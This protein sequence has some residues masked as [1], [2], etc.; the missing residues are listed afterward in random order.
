MARKITVSELKCACL[1]PAWRA[2][3]LAGERPPT[4]LHLGHGGV[5]TYSVVF[6]RLAEVFVGWLC[7]PI[8]GAASLESGEALWQ[9]LFDRFASDELTKL[10]RAN[11]VP[12]SHRFKQSLRAF[13]N[14]LAD[15]R[16]GAPAFKVWR[17]LYLGEEFDLKNVHIETSR[18]ALLIAGRV[19]AVRT[20][21]VH[22]VEVID[23][24]LSRG[25][26]AKHDLIQLAIYSRML[27]IAKPGLRFH[28]VLEY[29]EPELH[30]L[31]VPVQQLDSLFEEIVAP[32]LPELTSTPGDRRARGPD[33]AH[34]VKPSA[35]E[36]D[37][38]AAA[39][40]DCFAAFKLEVDVMD[41]IEAP[42]LVRYR[43]RPAPG[44]K[45]VSLANR[46]EDLQVRLALLQPPRIE[47]AQGYVHI[48]IPRSKPDTV[49]WNDVIKTPGFRQHPSPIA[50]PV[51]MGVDGKPMLADLADPNCCHALVAGSS[52]SGKS[53][54][55][56]SL[57]ASLLHRNQPKALKLTII[58]PKILTFGS[59][60]GSPYLTGPVITDLD[61]AV[62]RLDEA[63]AEMGQRYRDLAHEGFENL[64]QRLASG[65]QDL[66]FHVIVFD[67][68][69]DLILAGRETK[70]RFENLVTRLAAKG[71]A[72][73]MHLI[74]TTQRPD[75][76][77][78]TGLIKANLPRLSQLGPRSD[79]LD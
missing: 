68:F 40:R 24:K 13:C 75:R 76:K 74:L 65:R 42:Q 5:K 14:R 7:D 34:G 45:V 32:I 63:V 78:V 50:I 4:Q 58:D 51:G 59:L 27:A 16:A 64:S 28:G 77:V 12:A 26:Q 38:L 57:V 22:G 52:G 72:A 10:L 48:D 54:F 37:T 2:R 43:V 19:D 31:S 21:P 6:H 73:G 49:R 62:V 39:I 55:L 30:E 23:Y 11:Q 79:C 53:E 8:N 69:A 33:R 20:H 66:P 61:D 3:W 67:E 9:A 41:R 15:L 71:R 35:S 47:P 46:A 1:D 70:Q 25:A 18:D 17:D 44:V 36:E 56:K 29:Y 60:N